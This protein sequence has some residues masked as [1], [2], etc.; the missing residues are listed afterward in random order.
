ML[1]AISRFWINQPSTLQRFHW[2]H[3]MR[4]IAIHEYGTTWQAFPLSGPTIS[5][6]IS[7]SA[8]SPGWPENS[9]S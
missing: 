7:E 5:F 3:G 1:P 2:S 8:L 4:V 6:Q 9:H